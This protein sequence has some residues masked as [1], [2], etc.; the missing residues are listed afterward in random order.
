MGSFEGWSRVMGGL[1]K[2]IGVEGF[3]ENFQETISSYNP[4]EVKLRALFKWWSKHIRVPITAGALM[5]KVPEGFREDLGL[6]SSTAIGTRLRALKGAVYGGL[7]LQVKHDSKQN[8]YVY[9]LQQV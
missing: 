8:A 5:K 1:L 7:K 4:E 2:C 3:L 6:T 9:S